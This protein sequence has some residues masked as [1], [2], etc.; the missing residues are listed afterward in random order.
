MDALADL[1]IEVSSEA[2]TQLPYQHDFGADIAR[3]VPKLL[4]VYAA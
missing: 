2:F 3:T 1:A 4:D